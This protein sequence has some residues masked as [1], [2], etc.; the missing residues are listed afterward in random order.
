MYDLTLC[1]TL[2]IKENKISKWKLSKFE[3]VDFISM[4]KPKGGGFTS[5][6]YCHVL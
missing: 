6:N 4:F 2:L 5:R 1:D 3:H